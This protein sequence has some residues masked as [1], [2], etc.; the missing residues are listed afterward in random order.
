MHYFPS[1]SSN[2]F[3]TLKAREIKIDRDKSQG[4]QIQLTE[5]VISDG[6]TKGDGIDGLTIKELVEGIICQ[7]ER[8]KNGP[9]IQSRRT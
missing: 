9:T 7:T 1:K 6:V 8:K 2:L 3:F 4:R 5:L